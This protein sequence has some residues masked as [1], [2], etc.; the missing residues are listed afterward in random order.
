M[1]A[2]SWLLE[3]EPLRSGS[4]READDFRLPQDDDKGEEQSLGEEARLD[5]VMDTGDSGDKL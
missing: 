5:S 3:T 2:Y 4:C 1:S